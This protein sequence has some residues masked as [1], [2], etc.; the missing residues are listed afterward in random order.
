MT[1]ILLLGFVVGM[2]HALEADHLAA[3][4]AL[5]ARSHSVRHA[6][7]QG[8]VW[9][10]G[11][12]LT[13]LLF[14]AIILLSG[15]V[16]A[17]FGEWLERLVGVLL[18]LLG[19]DVVAKLVR[20]RIHLHAHRHRDGTVHLHAHSHLADVGDCPP[21]HVHGHPAPFPYR[22]LAVGVVHGMAGSAALVLLALEGV[23]SVWLGLVY[24]G[25]FGLGSM[26][27]MA[28]LSLVVV[29]PLRYSARHATVLH[30]GL[31]AA[32]ATVTIVVGTV[33]LI[34]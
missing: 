13:L 15:G 22:A 16:S 32:L 34:G 10:L 31:H 2:R 6:I 4:A 3:V 33:V 19:L 18:I 24:V 27:G 20:G 1:S 11:H 29:L 5:A 28:L 12:A 21:F 23:R 9:G 30:N 14:G 26:L 17:V 8:A 7:Y 25:L